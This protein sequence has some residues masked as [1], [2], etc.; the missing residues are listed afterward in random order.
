MQVQQEHQ[1][2]S[3]A[4]LGR[5]L[6]HWRSVGTMNTLET[7]QRSGTMNSLLDLVKKENLKY[8]RKHAF[9]ERAILGP[10]TTPMKD[11]TAMK[12]PSRTTVVS[13]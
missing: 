2:K 10:T 12:V 13:Q 1:S 8:I 4:N 3:A 5:K 9:E 7:T 6:R 11:L